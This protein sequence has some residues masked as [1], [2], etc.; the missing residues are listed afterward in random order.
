[1]ENED[2]NVKVE[3]VILIIFKVDE[4]DRCNCIGENKMKYIDVNGRLYTE[5]PRRLSN[6]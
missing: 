1:M 6:T 4:N 5:H 3:V 2:Y